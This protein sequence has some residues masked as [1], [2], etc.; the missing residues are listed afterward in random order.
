MKNTFKNLWLVALSLSVFA[1]SCD[2]DDSSTPDQET[3]NAEELVLAAQT[4]EIDDASYNIID[5]AYIE[6]V[7]D[8]R[9]ATLNSFFPECA[10]VTVTP[11]GDGSG[12]IVVNFGEECTLNNGALVSGQVNLSYSP[13]QNESREIVYQYQDFTYNENQVMGSGTVVRTFEN[14]NGNPESV[15][16]SDITIDFATS[17]V[18]AA[19]ILNRTRE[20]VEGVGSGTWT[21]NAFLVSGTWNT[22]FTN[23]TS[24]NGEVITALRREAT[25]PFFVSGTLAITNQNGVSGLLDYGDGSC[26]NIAVVTIEA[27]E[28][29]IML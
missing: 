16:N 6:N 27:Q 25:C 19:R 21:D 5:N 4:D 17:D 29:T 13:V 24:R 1:V 7:L 23:G 28:F 12:S 14:A 22:S 8:T 26:D 15:L 18:S 3:I 9:A 10:L 20:W 11:N 2:D